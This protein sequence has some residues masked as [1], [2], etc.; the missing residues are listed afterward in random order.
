MRKGYAFH[1]GGGVLLAPILCNLCSCRIARSAPGLARLINFP[2]DSEPQ[3]RK[4]QNADY[5]PLLISNSLGRVGV[6]VGR[7]FLLEPR[8]G[9]EAM[10]HYPV[11]R[12]RREYESIPSPPPPWPQL[13]RFD[14]IYSPTAH[15]TRVVGIRT[16]AD[17]KCIWRHLAAQYLYF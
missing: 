4:W 17:S 10:P 11:T 8:P 13:F 6:G 12:A 5:A 9:V 16:R 7:D 3:K 14:S 1:G 15:F 2:A